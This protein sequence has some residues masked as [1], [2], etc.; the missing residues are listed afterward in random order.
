M[1]RHILILAFVFCNILWSCSDEEDTP[2]TD[3]DMDGD[4]DGDSDSDDPHCVPEWCTSSN[5]CEEALC[6]E[7]NECETASVSDGTECPNGICRDGVCGGCLT[8]DECIDDQQCVLEI[9]RDHEE[10]PPSEESIIDGVDWV[11]GI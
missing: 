7:D 8:D 2:N 3:G 10:G 4:I 5:P 9:C 6:N 11:G 1:Y